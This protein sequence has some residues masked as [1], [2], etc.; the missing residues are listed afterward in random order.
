[1]L[2][3][4]AF[5]GWDEERISRVGK[6]YNAFIKSVNEKGVKFGN[7]LTVGEKS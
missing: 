2:Q 7:S 1:M 6:L 5:V 3:V 4:K